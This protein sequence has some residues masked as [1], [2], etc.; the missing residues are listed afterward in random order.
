HIT[1]AGCS[2]ISSSPSFATAASVPSNGR[3]ARAGADHNDIASEASAKR[4]KPIKAAC[5]TGTRARMVAS[6]LRRCAENPDGGR[7]TSCRP[8]RQEKP[9][10]L[11]N[12]ERRART[13]DRWDAREPAVGL[14]L[15]VEDIQEAFAAAHIR[16]MSLGIHK[17]IV[18]ITAGLHSLLG[19]AIVHRE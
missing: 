18:R 7:L 12:E 14:P 5:D 19:G 17:Q 1:P 16:A 8:R 15:H 6:W 11:R 4:T 10:Q 3:Y 2:S 9:V 13:R